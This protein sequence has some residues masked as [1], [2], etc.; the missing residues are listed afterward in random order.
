MISTVPTL[1]R[2]L[3]L[4]AVLAAAVPGDEAPPGGAFAA[5]TQSAAL[6][7]DLRDGRVFVAARIEGQ[8][9]TLLVDPA[10][11]NALSPAVATK[12][13][14]ARD[15]SVAAAPGVV[16]VRAPTLELGG[17]TLRDQPFHLL[18]LQRWREFEPV[19][20]D[21]VLGPESFAE[22]VL[23]LDYAARL[24]T[25][26]APAAFR[27]PERAVRLPLRFVERLPLVRASVDG[28]SGDFAIEPAARAPLV[29]HGGFV[30]E[31][32][33]LKV[34]DHRHEGVV[35][36]GPGGE[37]RGYATRIG[38]F[39]WGGLRAPQVVTILRDAARPLPGGRRLDGSIGGRLLARF[40]VSIDFVGGALLLEPNAALATPDAHDRSGMW[41]NL[42]G[43]DLLIAALTPNGPG[44]RSQLQAHDRIVAVDGVA[45][46]QL[47]LAGLR[48]RLTELPPGTRVRI[49]ARRDGKVIYANLILADLVPP[50][51]AT[52]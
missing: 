1:R 19:P 52:P 37:E 40:T 36:W 17:Y 25:L 14:L 39:E 11:A 45:A 26:T 50:P 20:V 2:L 21:G 35:G 3:P 13:G 6:R 48:Q 15:P 46:T 42:D 24:M 44:A 49:T 8:S 22:V 10:G 33:L 43:D 27:A 41:I 4:L 18:E 51:P 16:T 34:Y 32:D 29:L 12:L 7:I 28:R 47:T 38:A 9:V 30:D 23:T 31:H 5:G